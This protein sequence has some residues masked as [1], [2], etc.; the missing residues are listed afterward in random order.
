MAAK[1]TL[2]EENNLEENTQ[3]ILRFTNNKSK[4]F[5][6]VL[7]A[8]NIPC[9]RFHKSLR[10]RILEEAIDGRI[11]T[12][13]FQKKAFETKAQ[14]NFKLQVKIFCGKTKH[15]TPASSQILHIAGFSMSTKTLHYDRLQEKQTSEKTQLKHLQITNYNSRN[16]ATERTGS[17]RLLRRFDIQSALLT[18]VSGEYTFKRNSNCV[19]NFARGVCNRKSPIPTLFAYFITSF[20]I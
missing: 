16:S 6:I 9:P 15:K 20:S 11:Q 10:F 1:R 17:A 7:S 4:Y 19:K 5:S 18:V 2:F 12:G 13:S 3:K 8:R 14:K